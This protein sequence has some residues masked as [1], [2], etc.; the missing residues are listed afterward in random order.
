MSYDYF[1][2]CTDDQI[3]NVPGYYKNID[4]VL[5]S[6]DNM[7]MLEERMEKMLEVCLRKNMKLH[8]MD[9]LGVK[10]GRS[11]S[12]NPQSKGGAERVCKSIREVLEKKE[13]KGLT[14]WNSV[15]FQSQQHCATRG[16]RICSRE[17]PKEEP[18]NTPTRHNE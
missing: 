1:N 16:Q 15:S 14:S 6:A 7:G 11:S 4:D 17:I 18:K 2:L 5:L 9:K 3:R 13:A 8:E 10:L 12:Y